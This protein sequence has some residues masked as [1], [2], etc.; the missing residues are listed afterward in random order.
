[1]ATNPTPTPDPDQFKEIIENLVGAAERVM[2]NQRWYYYA[3]DGGLSESKDRRSCS[4][5][6]SVICEG[7]APSAMKQWLRDNGYRENSVGLYAYLRHLGNHES[8]C[9]LMDSLQSWTSAR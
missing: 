2:L 6:H 3:D 1:M 8:D 4:S 5:C 7:L 9:G